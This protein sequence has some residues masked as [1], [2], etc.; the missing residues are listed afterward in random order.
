[1]RRPVAV[2]VF[3]FAA[4]ALAS[5][6]SG[7]GEEEETEVVEG[8]PVEVGELEYN[9]GL[10]RFL[11]PDDNEDSEY[12]V[13][14]PPPEPRTAYLG[15]FLT[16]ENPTEDPLLSAD[17]YTV[18]DTLDT[19]YET[20]D[21]ES[22]YALEIGTEVPADGEQPLPNSTAATGPNQGALLI[23]LLDES[24]SENRPLKLAVESSETSGEVVLDI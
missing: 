5:A 2:L 18:H 3:L 14:L 24:V 9:V 12:L 6:V 16:I 7:C 22:P 10:T 11:N 8:E 20:V 15:V 21:S 1:M 19:A 4:L 13:G 23:F 17:A